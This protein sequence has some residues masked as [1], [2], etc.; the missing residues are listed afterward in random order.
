MERLLLSLS[1]VAYIVVPIV[2]VTGWIR[3]RRRP[4]RDPALGISFI[5]FVLGSAS[6]LLAACSILVAFLGEGFR[7]YDPALL[8]IYG[9][10]ILL[11]LGGLVCATIGA[12]RRS[13]LRWYALALSLGM[14]VL[15]FLWASSE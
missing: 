14:L 8:K 1:I 9:I 10:G 15:W 13:S 5:G 11:S 2:L 3:W 12:F 6:A 4:S 7:Y